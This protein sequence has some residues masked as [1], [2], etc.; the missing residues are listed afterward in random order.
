MSSSSCCRGS[1][2]FASSRAST[3]AL[4]PTSDTARSPWPASPRRWSW[5]APTAPRRDPGRRPTTRRATWTRWRCRAPWP[6]LPNLRPASPTTRRTRANDHHRRRSP[7]TTGPIDGVDV[8]DN[9]LGT[10]SIEDAIEENAG[11]DVGH[12]GRVPC[13]TGGVV[14]RHHEE[15]R[16][17]LLGQLP[18]E[19]HEPLVDRRDAVQEADTTRPSKLST[20][21]EATLGG[22]I[23]KSRLWFFGAGRYQDTKTSMPTSPGSR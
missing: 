20:N 12:L 8:N 16:R 18:R 14:L 4:P 7:T 19:P 11:A 15:G 21:F 6:R 22:P 10:P 13:F 5:W 3:S 2:P 9:L 17:H 23:V 1:T